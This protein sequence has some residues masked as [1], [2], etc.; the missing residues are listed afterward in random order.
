MKTFSGT[1]ANGE[2]YM[3]VEA[4]EDNY[5][6]QITHHGVYFRKTQDSKWELL[7]TVGLGELIGAT[8][9]GKY[10]T[11]GEIELDIPGNADWVESKLGVYRDYNDNNWATKLKFFL[12]SESLI[13]LL[14]RDSRKAFPLEDE[15]EGWA[16]NIIEGLTYEQ[17]EKKVR[18]KTF[19]IIL[20]K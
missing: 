3:G 20:V 15:M 10:H 11:K 8:I 12:P 17:H 16:D 5:E 13:S 9:L 4:P 6:Y 19:L 14:D 7:H 18:P 2:K 1:F